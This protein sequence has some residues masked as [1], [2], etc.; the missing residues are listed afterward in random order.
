MG[1]KAENVTNLSDAFVLTATCPD[2]KRYVVWQDR[3]TPCFGLRIMKTGDKYWLMN[4][5]THGQRSLGKCSE[6]KASRARVLAEEKLEELKT[7]KEVHTTT[8]KPTLR[9]VLQMYFRAKDIGEKT[10]KGMETTLKIYGANLYDIPMKDVTQS[11]A[12]TTTEDAWERSIRQGDL[13]K[14]YAHSLYRYQ[15]IDSPFDGIKNRYIAGAAPFALPA[16]NMSDFL[17]AIDELRLV[18]TRDILWTS[19]LTGFRPEAVVSMRWEHLDLTPG[20]ASYF[21]APGAPGFKDGE[22]WRYPLP[23]FLAEKLRTRER[24]HK[25]GEWVFHNASDSNKHVTGFRDAVLKLRLTAG[26]PTLQPYHIRDTRGTYCERFFGQTIV[27]QRLL[28]HR[29]DYVPTE[30]MIHEH[31]VPTS[32]STYR[33]IATHAHEIRSYVERYSDI[34]LELGGRLPM[35]DQV[36]DVF[37]LNKALALMERFTPG[38]MPAESVALPP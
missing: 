9:T 29:P 28:N 26:I 19:L 38:A 8:S 16:E 5:R 14:T 25:Y 22:T 21:I 33:Y 2:G 27:T 4:S 15:K 6:M 17:D 12:M 31:K 20:A 30:W 35:T 32:R 11:L 10:R 1:R 36:R 13:L 18:T 23:E 34:I 3:D 7:G 24:R 37:L